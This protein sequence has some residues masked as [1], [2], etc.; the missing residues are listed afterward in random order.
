M[1]YS[2]EEMRRWFLK[3]EI[4][5]L[6]CRFLQFL[7]QDIEEFFAFYKEDFNFDRVTIFRHTDDSDLK[8][9]MY[10]VILL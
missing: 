9:V 7:P 5:L 6:R 10:T 2:S 3:Q 1:S 4:E 8:Q